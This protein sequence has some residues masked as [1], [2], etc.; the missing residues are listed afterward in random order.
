M[1]CP[2][3]VLGL[4]AGA[5][6][7]A[8]KSAYR[9]LALTH[10][11]DKNPG[12]AGATGRFAEVRDA[13]ERITCPPPPPE[14]SGLGDLRDM[15]SGLFGTAQTR[16]VNTVPLYI[17]LRDIMMGAERTIVVEAASRCGECK[18]GRGTSVECG[19]CRGCGRKQVRTNLPGM[20]L[21]EACGEC[22]GTGR[23]VTE[24]CGTCGGR[25]A[26]TGRTRVSVQIPPGMPNGALL[27]VSEHDFVDDLRVRVHHRLPANVTMSDG[28][29]HWCESVTIRDALVGVRRDITV[30]EG[31]VLEVDSKGPLDA[32]K[33]WRFRGRGYGGGAVIVRWK[34]AWD[35]APLHA[36]HAALLEC[37]SAP[38]AGASAG[39]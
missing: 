38:E 5:P 32:S 11:P 1:T 22:S 6:L 23:R 26:V 7:E 27:K 35:M 34:V 14:E 16:G 25:G 10:H 20:I 3:T 2:Y 36:A 18:G 21:M 29:V 31:T 17:D 15:F 39:A 37:L 8:V 19:A 13:F 9:K 33:S 4:P 24:A 30:C 28:D 12:D